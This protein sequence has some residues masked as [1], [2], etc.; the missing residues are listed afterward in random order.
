[1]G[2]RKEMVLHR[3]EQLE[4]Y[5]NILN[6]IRSLIEGAQY[7]AYKAIDNLRVQAYWQ[8]GERIVRG[9]LEHKE[10]AD[11]GKE[12]IGRLARDL[13]F[14]KRDMYRI[15]RNRPT[16]TTIPRTLSSCKPRLSVE[17]CTIDNIVQFYRTYPIVTSL[18]SQLSW[19]HY[20]ILI[21][22]T[23]ESKRRFYEIQTIKN[24]WSTRRLED[25]VKERLYENARKEGKLVEI[26]NLPL[27][28]IEPEMVFKD[29]YHFKFLKLTDNYSESVLESALLSDVERSLL[30]FGADFS[31]AGRQRPI[32]IDGEYHSVDIE[33][34]HRGIPCIVLVD[35]KIGKFK[36]EYVGQMNKYLNYYRENKKYEW[37]KD[38][39]GLIICEHKG[40]EEVH[41]AL[42]GLEKR[43]FVAEYKVNLPTEKQVG[44]Q[45]WCS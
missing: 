12:L 38:P 18:L 22:I 2:K 32:V 9:E 27:E 4:G 23:D 29:T 25:E 10:R 36:A 7:Q 17:L 41:Y 31:L 19:T 33:L 14:H 34:F 37:E 45:G 16:G 28:A 6:D 39:I 15:Q 43:I 42:G 8:I 21:K 35:L 30:E 24:S 1:M 26:S 3:D 5:D 44:R 20:T 11:Y 40:E 13:G